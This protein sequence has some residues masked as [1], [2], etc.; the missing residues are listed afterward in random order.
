MKIKIYMEKTGLIRIKWLF[1]KKYQKAYT[2]VDLLI[3]CTF[4]GGIS[5]VLFGIYALV[6]FLMKIW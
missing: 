5:L 2:I 4:L 1:A 3:L 6:H